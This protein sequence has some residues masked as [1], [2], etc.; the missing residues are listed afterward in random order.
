MKNNED[1]PRL[2]SEE[3]IKIDIDFENLNIR[4]R[5]R[6]PIFLFLLL[7]LLAVV[8]FFIVKKSQYSQNNDLSDSTEVIVD[9]EAVW[10]GAFASKEIFESCREAS[11]TVI[12]EGCRCSGFVYSE[13]GWIATVDGVVN[14]NVKGQIEVVLFD[15]R[16]FLVEAFRQNR[17]SG[18]TLMKIDAKGLRAAKLDGKGELFVGEELFT[19]CS[20]GTLS[21]G[22]SLFSGNVS[23]TEREVELYKHEGGV[24]KLCLF[25]IGILLTEEGV[26]AP[27]FNE[28][29]ELVGMAC[30]SG[31]GSERYM[32]DYAFAF[33][34]IKSLFERMKNGERAEDSDLFSII[35]E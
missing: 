27:L 35:V 15:G 5:R 7:I 13:D 33:C 8:G 18:I 4:K 24:R 3:K 17:E 34:N 9:N 23:H 29:G 28:R 20:V 2:E 31:D 10:H 19:F 21:D 14:E 6:F 32:V 22:G 1:I 25:Q 30:A 12:A 26:G 11:V 16:R